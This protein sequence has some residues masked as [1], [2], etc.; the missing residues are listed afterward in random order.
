MQ[1]EHNRAIPDITY[2]HSR[3]WYSSLRSTQPQLARRRIACLL[4]FMD[5]RTRDIC[6]PLTGCGTTTRQ[7]EIGDAAAA[8]VWDRERRGEVTKRVVDRDDPIRVA[9]RPVVL[10]RL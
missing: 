5:L 6:P 9:A 8:H 3:R 1:A 10:G 7:R 4:H 2:K